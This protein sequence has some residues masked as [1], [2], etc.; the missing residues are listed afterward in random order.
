MKSLTKLIFLS[1]LLLYTVESKSQDA[2]DLASTA[3]DLSR[4][5]PGGSARILGLGEAQTSLGGDISS[6]SGNPAGLGFFNR[7]EVSLSTTFNYLSSTSKYL[8]SS[9]DDARLNLNFGNLG[10]VI[11]NSKGSGLYKG[12]AF[13]ISINRIAD[14]Q[15]QITYEG[16][17]FNNLDGNGNIV[18]DANRPADFVEF[19][20]LSSSSDASGNI[21]FD[22]D[23]AELAYE[24][25][26]ISSFQDGNGDYFVDRDFYAVDDNGN[27]ITDGNGNNIP[28][29]SEP[30]FPVIQSEN[31][32]STGATYQTSFAYGGNYNDRLYF[33]GNIGILTMSK[34]VE[35]RYTEKPTNADLNGLLLEDNYDL[36]GS[37]VVATIGFIGRPVNPLLLGISYTTPSYYAIE[38]KRN[39]T[40]T[41]NYAGNDI[42]SYGFDYDPFNYVIT[43]PSRLRLGA[44]YFIGKYGFLT[45]DVEKINYAGA[46]L[47]N[48]DIDQSFTEENSTVNTFESVWNYR[49]GAEFRYDIFRLRGGFSYAADP[50]RNNYDQSE[51]KISFGGGIRTEKFYIDLAVVN[52]LGRQSSIS[53]YPGQE[54]A[55]V[56]NKN[57][58]V[59]VT[60]GFFF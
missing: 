24:T 47:S 13:G 34:S 45:G 60:T 44:T 16:S 29:Y 40:L 54:N 5:T 4:A 36:T 32:K 58:G 11:K 57:T 6:I 50:V 48:S 15:N 7:S 26:L 31:V 18:F 56:N 27:L 14:F 8:G 53:P 30:N 25:F 17:S 12:G 49:L 33:G 35:R 21:S 46:K 42:K 9:S 3:L 43:T 39:I 52:G 37:G 55:I 41:A 19:A 20:V 28:A 22:N 23:F 59:S 1:T 10:V 51:S 38:Q 2:S